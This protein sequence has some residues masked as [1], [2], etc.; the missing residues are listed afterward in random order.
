MY[1]HDFRWKKILSKPDSTSAMVPTDLNNR[2]PVLRVLVVRITRALV[3]QV[4]VVVVGGGGGVGVVAV[5]VD[6]IQTPNE[7]KEIINSWLF[8]YDMNLGPQLYALCP[9]LLLVWQNMSK[10]KMIWFDS[11]K[12]RAKQ[13]FWCGCL[14][15]YFQEEEECNVSV[16][17]LLELHSTQATHHFTK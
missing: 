4:R 17:V 8:R 11:T 14:D 5:L 7:I 15:S 16:T 6:L 13:M 9:H 2:L 10:Y 1:I 3:L 12:W